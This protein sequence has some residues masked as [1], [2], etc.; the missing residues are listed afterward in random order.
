GTS[1]REVLEAR[2]KNNVYSEHEARE[3]VEVG[4]AK[5][6]EY[7]SE[8]I[9]LQDGRYISVV[10]RPLA[11]GGLITTHEDVTDRKKADAQIAHMAMHDTLTGL[12]NR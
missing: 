2:V 11:N 12:P 3:M 9:A 1:L 5:F 4:I 7:L 8:I 10:R 6:R